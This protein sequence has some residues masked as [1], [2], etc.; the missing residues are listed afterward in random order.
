[1]SALFDRY[2]HL[3]LGVCLKYLKSP[4]LA[5]D[6]TQRIFIKLLD[7][8][9]RFKIDRFKPWLLQVTRNF[10]LMELRGSVPVVNNEIGDLP[11]MEYEEELHQKVERERVYEQLEKAIKELGKEQRVCV[12]LFYLE[13][14]TYSEISEKT[15]YSLNDVKSFLQNGKRNLKIRMEA[16]TDVRS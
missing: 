6:A 11:D 14:L 8:L 16:L 2:G 9:H 5:K 12:E 10:C 7:D 3:V 15:G 13:K 1:M 4:D